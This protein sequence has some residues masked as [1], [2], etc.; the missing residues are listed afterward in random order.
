MAPLQANDVNTWV[1]PTPGNA[2]TGVMGEAGMVPLTT[3][4]AT[5]L[6]GIWA[7]DALNVGLWA[8]NNTQ[9]WNCQTYLNIAGVNITQTYSVEAPVEDER[10]T[11]DDGLALNKDGSV[12]KRQPLGGRGKPK[13]SDEPKLT[14][15][16]QKAAM[17]E[18]QSVLEDSE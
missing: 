7:S 12:S 10:P 2:S 13:T 11:N 8:P 6:G 18:V 16:V 14:A 1:P 17:S 3:A 5:T 9:G 4:Q 15:E